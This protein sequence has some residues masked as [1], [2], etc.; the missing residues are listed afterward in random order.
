MSFE[1]TSTNVLIKV[2]CEMIIQILYSV[3][4]FWTLRTIINTLSKQIR[5]PLQRVLIHRIN[6]SQINDCK[7][8]N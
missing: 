1:K 2:L 4:W 5:E 7:E 6:Y 3:I 8:E